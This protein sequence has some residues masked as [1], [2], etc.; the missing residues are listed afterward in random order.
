MHPP[1]PRIA[2]SDRRIRQAHARPSVNDEAV[3]L[4]SRR[5][6]RQGKPSA[7]V[8]RWAWPQ[9]TLITR[10]Q[11]LMG[12]GSIDR[13]GRR[14]AIRGATFPPFLTAGRTVV[15]LNLFAEREW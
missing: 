2:H 10:E 4:S 9:E 3:S 14:A 7:R 15:C 1:Y 13:H 6:R 12:G 11:M 8:R 5:K